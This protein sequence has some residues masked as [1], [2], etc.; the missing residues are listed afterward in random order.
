[1]FQ[2]QGD[3]DLPDGAG[4]ETSP[5]SAEVVGSIPGRTAKVSQPSWLKNIKQKQ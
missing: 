1:M 3:G 4:V 2:E 5:S